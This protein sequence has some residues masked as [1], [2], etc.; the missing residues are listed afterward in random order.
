MRTLPLLPPARPTHLAVHPRKP[1][2]LVACQGIDG[3]WELR[4]MHAVTGELSSTRETSLLYGQVRTCATVRVHM[5][6]L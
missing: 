3:I 4:C 5:G 2:L 6:C 1:V